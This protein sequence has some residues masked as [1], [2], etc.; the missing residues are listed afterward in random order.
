MNIH[1]EEDYLVL[2]FLN[3]EEALAATETMISAGYLASIDSVDPY[4][5]V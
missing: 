1:K 5:Y 3:E 2:T 4:C